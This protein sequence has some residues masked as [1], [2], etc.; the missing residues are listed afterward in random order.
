[1]RLIGLLV[2]AASACLLWFVL[3]QRPDETP[4]LRLSAGSKGGEYLQ[5]AEALSQVARETRAG[6]VIDVVESDGA[7]MNADRL[8]SDEADLGMLQSDTPF[9]A[10]VA[11][12]VA[13]FPEMMHIVARQDAGIESPSDL[14]GKRLALMPAGSGSNRLFFHVMEHYGFDRDSF[15]V[16]EYRP[17]DAMEAIKTGKADA[18]IRVIALGNDTMH[19]LL[20]TPGL[21]LVPIDQAEAIR[22]FSPSLERIV[23]PRGA[24]S[25][26][27]VMPPQDIEGIGVRAVLA[28]RAQVDS[29]VIQNLTALVVDNK[30]RL[31][32]LDKTAAL[33]SDDTPLRALGLSIHP[34]A[35]R[36][37]NAEKPSFL[38]EYSDSIGLGLSVFVLALSG[39]WQ[40]IRWLD[41]R[42]KNR[43]DAY[44]GEISALLGRLRAASTMAEVT[45]VESEMY[46][47]FAKVVED[48]DKDRL[49]AETLPSFD[50]VWRSAV[51][52]AT[53][54]R[55][56][57]GMHQDRAGLPSMPRLSGLAAD[58]PAGVDHAES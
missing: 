51:T 13:L 31:R 49:A 21:T 50:F 48:L 45:R 4:H 56:E 47:V 14:A 8:A 15:T 19:E 5:F 35:E 30:N 37:F 39:L 9:E 42:R 38:V 28:A 44:T 40:V 22:M 24:L 53:Q 36:H 41:A 18:M 20:K 29:A 25:G 1:L 12:V 10:D 43:G 11:A 55:A 7:N 54:R 3:A 2:A 46:D 17:A 58:P 16:T 33:I 6:V 57:L 26:R 34:G 27:P 52:L 32:E 23:V